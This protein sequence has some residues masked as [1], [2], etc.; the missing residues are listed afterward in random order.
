[1]IRGPKPLPTKLKL[2][3]GNPGKR[4]IN[5]NEPTAE[6]ERP[7]PPLTD[8]LKARGKKE[9][10]RLCRLL[11]K[12]GVMTAVDRNELTMYCIAWENYLH[13]EEQVKKFGQ[14]GKSPNDYPIQNPFV[15]IA[16]KEFAKLITIGTNFGM[17]PSARVRLSTENIETT[18]FGG[19]DD[20]WSAIQ[21]D[22]EG[23][24]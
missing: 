6:I 15:A 11:E 14:V 5:E 4:K 10:R 8:A 21:R 13:A 17:N 20:P 7:E 24:E 22:A 9:Y 2:V 23:S 12:M 3:R 18:D 16:S 19:E 1:M